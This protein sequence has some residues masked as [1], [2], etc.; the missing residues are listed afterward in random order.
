MRSWLAAGASAL[1]AIAAPAAAAAPTWLPVTPLSEPAGYGEG[2][3]TAVNAAGAAAAAWVGAPE[4]GQT[5]RL[6]VAIH[7]PGGAWTV[8]PSPSLAIPG[9]ACEPHVGVDDTGAVTVV[10][11][12]L[13]SPTTGICQ[14]GGTPGV[15][16]AT[17]PPGGTAF[18]APT[19]LSSGAVPPEQLDVAQ[20]PSGAAVAAWVE[21]TG[22]D[23][24][25]RAALRPAGGAFTTAP[26]LDRSGYTQLAGLSASIAAD[27]TAA[28]AWQEEQ[29]GFTE[30]NVA[31]VVRPAGGAWPSFPDAITQHTNTSNLTT[32]IGQV[33]LDVAPGGELTVVYGEQRTGGIAVPCGGSAGSATSAIC[34]RRRPAGGLWQPPET[35]SPFA[36]TLEGL[37]LDIGANGNAAAAWGEG[38]GFNVVVHAARRAPGAGWAGSTALPATPTSTG[39]HTS[40]AVGVLPDGG[41]VAAWGDFNQS[42]R[43][44]AL[45]TPTGVW[46]SPQIVATGVGSAT[47]VAVDGRGNAVVGLLN[48]AAA[49]VAL[50]YSGPDLTPGVPASGVA[51]VPVDLSV[52]AADRWSAVAGTPQWVFGDGTTGTGAAAQHVFAAPGTYTV[53]V[54]QADALGN[55]TTVERQIAIAPPPPPPPPPA[56]HLGKVA[57][58]VKWSE[59]R[60]SGRLV[61][62]GTADA[63]AAVTGTLERGKFRR[64]VRFSVKAGAFTARLAMPATLLPGRFVLRLGGRAGAVDLAPATAT[65]TLAAPR[66]GV[67]DRV[68]TSITRGGPDGASFTG[69]VRALHVSFHFAALPR[70]G[71]ALHMDILGPGRIRASKAWRGRPVGPAAILRQGG[72]LLTKGRWRF[73]LKSGATV[74]KRV[75]VVVR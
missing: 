3:E 71:R 30:V 66:E 45:A 29:S 57:F 43:V 49:V 68:R 33:A 24:Q 28:I 73:V 6:R 16:A 58:A 19:Q 59:S 13:A 61:V 54:S 38:V 7:Q 67:V 64:S 40:P 25:F 55:A 51:G 32:A 22:N 9:I 20:A 31:A 14:G 36:N 60:L 17:L 63:A 47:S 46:S 70:A 15:W 35:V 56:L 27:G 50:D 11:M 5:E 53:S 4:F 75:S 69:R 74:V 44:A 52:V 37:A 72:Q 8:P 26:V 1:L 39:D 12:Q 65:V 34:T 42:A 21:R 48:G 41:A 10:W 18:S 62:P 23:W 2:V